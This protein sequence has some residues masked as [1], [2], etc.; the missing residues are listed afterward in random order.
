MPEALL[1][2]LNGWIGIIM[3]IAAG[4]AVFVRTENR[5][6]ENADSIK[7]EERQRKDE[8]ARL[9]RMRIEDLAR[10]DKQRAD[11]LRAGERAIER[12]ENN[13]SEIAK[14]IKALLKHKDG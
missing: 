11:D 1:D 13:L 4:V 2:Q 6:R 5:T 10:Y 9:E 8:I 3:A 12:I 7:S 14:D